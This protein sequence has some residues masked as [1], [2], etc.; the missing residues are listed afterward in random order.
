MRIISGTLK[1]RR[2]EKPKNNLTRPLKDMT[3]ESIFNI[4]IHS[5][6][7][8]FD[9]KNAVILDVFSGSG[10]FGIE[11]LS[12]GAKK[13]YFIEN[14]KIAADVLNINIKKLKLENKTKL[15]QKDFLKVNS[16]NVQTKRLDLIFFDP[17]FK[18]KNI[19]EYFNAASKNNFINK[20]T[21]II[22]HRHKNS[23]D[24]IPM[25]FEEKEC[26]IYGISKIYFFKLR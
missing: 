20:E 19:D 5:K 7:L 24:K 26:K 8:G 9:I 4:L 25:V 14:Y 3:K 13:V 22:L 2:L 18:T 17:P 16:F 10:S 1:G 12:R 15:I 11:C 6:I 21:L 23:K